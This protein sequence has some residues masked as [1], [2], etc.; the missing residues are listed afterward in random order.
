MSLLGWRIWELIQPLTVRWRKNHTF[1]IPKSSKGC[2]YCFFPMFHCYLRN[3]RKLSYTAE[4]CVVFR[5]HVFCRLLT[6]DYGFRE[7]Q[8]K[9]TFK[10]RKRTPVDGTPFI[11]PYSLVS[12]SFTIVNGPFSMTWVRCHQLKD[13]AT[14]TQLQ[15]CTTSVRAGQAPVI[16]FAISSLR[17]SRGHKEGKATAGGRWC[18]RSLHVCRG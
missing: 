3:N 6:N 2:S 10:F 5:T 18:L 11:P 7:Q 15:K 8:R 9:H 4:I 13:W 12:S 16:H 17:W 1:Q 14:S